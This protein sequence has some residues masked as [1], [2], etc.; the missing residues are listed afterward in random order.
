MWHYRNIR[1]RNILKKMSE[2]ESMT[3]IV[4]KGMIAD[5]FKGVKAKNDFLLLAAGVSDSSEKLNSE[6]LREK[7]V[8]SE[9][10]LNNPD[11]KVIYFSTCSIYG[12]ARTPYIEHKLEMEKVVKES[13]KSYLIL[14]LPQVVGFTR[15]LTLISF[16]VNQLL[17]NNNLQIKINAKRNL[18]D[19]CD[20]VR[21]TCRLLDTV[22]STQAIINIAS[23]ENVPIFDIVKKVSDIL[24]VNANCVEI[25][26]GE[27]YSI[28]TSFI[29]EILGFDDPVFCDNYWV[30]IL[31]KYVPILSKR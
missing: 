1:L 10:I 14:R 19:V 9:A 16:V 18:I 26:G 31:E 13:A 4:G 17:K 7:I 8:I 25:P 24:N 20:V 22:K 15:N 2:D 30:S 5:A 29:E 21:I 3:V 6:F 23:K 27:A 28:S 11:L 12:V